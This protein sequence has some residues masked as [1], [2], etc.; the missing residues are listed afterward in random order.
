MLSRVREGPALTRIRGCKVAVI[1]AGEEAGN[2]HRSIGLILSNGR[3]GEGNTTMH[4]ELKKKMQVDHTAILTNLK[5]SIRPPCS[6][7]S[8]LPPPSPLHSC[9]FDS[10]TLTS[11][12]LERGISLPFPFRLFGFPPSLTVP[13]V[14]SSLPELVPR[15]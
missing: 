6:H 8:T 3:T 12:S 5:S 13:S 7:E 11:T 15:R 9:W 2:R 10:F 4:I 1:L 14:S